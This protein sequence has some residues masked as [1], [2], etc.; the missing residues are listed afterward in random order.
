MLHQILTP[1]PAGQKD[2]GVSVLNMDFCGQ[3]KNA[4]QGWVEFTLQP[5]DFSVSHLQPN[6]S[7]PLEEFGKGPAISTV[8]LLIIS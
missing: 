3:E 8:L 6:P 7:P 5:Q 4:A 1:V 2:Y